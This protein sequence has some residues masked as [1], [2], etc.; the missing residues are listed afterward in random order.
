MTTGVDLRGHVSCNVR[1][2]PHSRQLCFVVRADSAVFDLT[3]DGSRAANGLQ[4]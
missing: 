2:L 4:S 1:V 3:Y